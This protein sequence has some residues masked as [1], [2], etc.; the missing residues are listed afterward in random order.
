MASET[1]NLQDFRVLESKVFT[2]RDRGL[3]VRNESD[4]DKKVDDGNEIEVVVPED[5]YSINPSFLE[6]FFFNAVKKLGRNEFYERVHI[7]NEGSYK[8][9]R[10]LDEAVDRIL[11]NYNALI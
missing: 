3:Q 7:K 2:G 11:R 1:I 4:L 8:I 9:K 6:E 10:D 5:I